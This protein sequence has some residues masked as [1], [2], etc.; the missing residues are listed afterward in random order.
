MSE[1][2]NHACIRIFFYWFTLMEHLLQIPHITTNHNLLLNFLIK[3]F[4]ILQA[5]SDGWR[6][7]Y[8]GGDHFEFYNSLHNKTKNFID[9]YS[10]VA[11]LS[12][13]N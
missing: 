8:I 5:A 6:V 12:M 1:T 2:R 4:F 9:K 3:Y 13:F 11:K 7:C 10:S